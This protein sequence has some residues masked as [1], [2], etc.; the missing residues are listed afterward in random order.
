MFLHR[1]EVKWLLDT[2][3]APPEVVEAPTCSKENSGTCVVPI[4]V[5][6]A[7]DS[8]GAAT[9][10]DSAPS[11]TDDADVEAGAVSAL[12]VP[13]QAVA[14]V[15]NTTWWKAR[16]LPRSPSVLA[17][18]AFLEAIEWCI[19]TFGKDMSQW[20]WGTAH[21]VQYSHSNPKVR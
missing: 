10:T 9:I 16:L 8:T 13:D 11:I 5:E 2:F 14:K 20:K 15:T 17:Q 21:R 6:S 19:A 18:E 7:V 3:L 12:L 1:T 4:V